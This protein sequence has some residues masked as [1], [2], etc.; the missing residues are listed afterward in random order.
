[1][2]MTIIALAAAGSGLI[3]GLFFVFSISVMPALAAMPAEQGM[4][5][6]QLINR[7]II[8]AVFLLVFIGT[9]ILSL[10]VIGLSI[11]QQQAG[12][13]FAIA[14]AAL[15]LVGGIGITAVFNVPL[16]N[17]LEA[18]GQQAPS[19]QRLWSDYLLS[20]TRWNHV[21]TVVTIISAFLL[22]YAM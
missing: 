2:T 5:A 20:W 17:A 9:A 21:R 4:R 6:M 19:G 10:V 13:G 1:M 14:G 7:K 16:N 8:N 12:A 15:Y 18:V 22:A 3:A 11:S